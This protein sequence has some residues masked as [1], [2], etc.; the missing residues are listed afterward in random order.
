MIWINRRRCPPPGP[1][2]KREGHRHFALESYD[3]EPIDVLREMEVR[4]FRN[5]EGG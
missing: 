3:E 5:L 4:Y 2:R 1:A